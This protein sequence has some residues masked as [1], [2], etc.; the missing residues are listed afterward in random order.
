M[1]SRW[2]RSPECDA[3]HTLLV[4]LYIQYIHK[5]DCKHLQTCVYYNNLAETDDRILRNTNAA[6]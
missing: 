1:Y 4:R 6:K 3:I 2:V 5:H